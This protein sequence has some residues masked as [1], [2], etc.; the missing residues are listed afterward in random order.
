[1]SSN[2]SDGYMGNIWGWRWSI[3]S[4]IFIV[5]ILILMYGRYRYLV[6]TERYDPNI[7]DTTVIHEN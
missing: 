1:M 6:S 3:I 4:L 2:F 5:A 7:Q